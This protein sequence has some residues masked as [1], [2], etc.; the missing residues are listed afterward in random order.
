M[1]SALSIIL[2]FFIASVLLR[3]TYGQSENECACNQSGGFTTWGT[4]VGESSCIG[5]CDNAA[6]VRMRYCHV[7]DDAG[8]FIDTTTCR[9]A[10]KSDCGE[11]S[12]AWSS[13][14]SASPCTGTCGRGVQL[15]LRACYRVSVLGDTKFYFELDFVIFL[16]YLNALSSLK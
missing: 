6:L 15:Q 13:W 16:N 1:K 10:E 12:G 8:R 3:S 7:F 11:C 14:G 5:R 2:L 4:F 9:L